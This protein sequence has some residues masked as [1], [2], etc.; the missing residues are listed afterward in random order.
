MRLF[1]WKQVLFGFEVY[2]DTGVFRSGGM[3]SNLID[4]NRLSFLLFRSWV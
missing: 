2:F 1:P 3:S 4:F